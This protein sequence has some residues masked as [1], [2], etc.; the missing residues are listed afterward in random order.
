MPV[1]LLE[2]GKKEF[3]IVQNFT[4]FFSLTKM[5]KEATAQLPREMTRD[6]EQVEYKH[7]GNKI[8]AIKTCRTV[9][10]SI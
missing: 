8:P 2:K 4:D 6:A 7:E 5:S 1:I 10:S 3:R 9:T